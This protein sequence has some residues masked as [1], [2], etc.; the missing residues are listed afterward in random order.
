MQRARSKN[1]TSKK[2]KSKRKKKKK[3]KLTGFHRRLD[4]RRDSRT[5]RPRLRHVMRV[6]AQ[7]AAGE[8]A[9]NMSAALP[10]VLE[11]LEDEDA[12]ALCHFFFV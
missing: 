10:G 5:V 11:G 3:K 4:A 7:G 1:P 2:K 6:A 12:S 8:L 9:N